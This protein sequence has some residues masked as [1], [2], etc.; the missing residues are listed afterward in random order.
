MSR[1]RN[2]LLGNVLEVQ[3]QSRYGTKKNR[4]VVSP[5]GRDMEPSP[6]FMKPRPGFF[7]I[8][9]EN[10]RRKA[11]RI[12]IGFPALSLRIRAKSQPPNPNPLLDQGFPVNYDSPGIIGSHWWHL[13]PIAGS[14]PF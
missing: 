1:K 11:Y 9:L 13:H 14:V 8:K 10:R 3:Q 4:P 2:C 12:L 6:G 5:K 7:K